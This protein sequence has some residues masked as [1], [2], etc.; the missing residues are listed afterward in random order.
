MPIYPDRQGDWGADGGRVADLV[1]RQRPPRTLDQAER[2][3]T[4]GRGREND[5][6]EFA[7]PI[8]DIRNKGSDLLICCFV[9]TDCTNPNHIS[10]H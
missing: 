8:S 5:V 9:Y 4:Q 10:D 2:G 3:G 6:V 1:L 7:H